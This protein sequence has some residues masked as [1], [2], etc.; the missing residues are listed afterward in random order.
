MKKLLPLIIGASFF[1]NLASADTIFGIYAG[2]GN[3][4]P[5]FSGSIS[6]GSTDTIDFGNSGVNIADEDQSGFYIAVEHPIP[7]VPNI[8]ITEQD[9]ASS[10][11]GNFTGDFAGQSFAG[12]V[13][14]EF[15]LS[16]NDTTLYYEVLDN[17]VNLDLGITARTFDGLARVSDSV[18]N[19]IR[20]EDVLDE[21]VPMLYGK[22][23]FDLPFTGLSL[24]VIVNTL[25]FGDNGITDTSAVLG[26]ESSFGLGLEA[27]VRTFTLDLEDAGNF[28]SDL[29][30]D[31]AFVNVTY[32]F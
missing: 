1:S 4:K 7:F 11:T 29:E 30:F 28:G 21:T 15:D 14:T 19:A 8:M 10:G 9:M 3:W 27:G 13:D 18:N 26:Y 17:W 24:S 23:R 16:F 2:T 31:G 20:S 32:H 25:S 6:N 22:A 12:S 5:E